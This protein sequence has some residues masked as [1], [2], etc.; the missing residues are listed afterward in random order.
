MK[1][2]SDR[3][4][5]AFSL[6]VTDRRW[7]ATLSAAALGF[8]LFV[9]V[10]IGPNAAGTL[11]GTAQILEMPAP[12]D[13]EATAA[14]ADPSSHALGGSPGSSGGGGLAEAPLAPIAL[15]PPPPVAPA[16]APSAE[17]E[18]APEPA[19][20]PTEPAEHE[21]EEETEL[22]GVVVQANPAAGSFAL[23]IDGGELVPV[24]A[25]ELPSAGAKLTVTA[26][27]LAN[28]TFVEAEPPKR[29]G[30]VVQASFRGVVTYANP[31]PVAPAYTVSGRG[32]SLLVHVDPD[33]SGAPPQLPVLGSRVTVAAA[34]GDRLDQRAI[35]VEEGEPSTYLDLA[36]IVQA[37]IPE[38]KQLVLSADGLDES[39][40]DLILTVP[41]SIGLARIELG[42][43]YLATAEVQPD[44]S[45]ALA[46]LASDEHTKGA[47][48]AAATQGDLKAG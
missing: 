5:R 26:R 46:G 8:G 48:D 33:P 15:A 22:K 29:S 36:G 9:G 42:E 37:V 28:G 25:Q 2:V 21:D 6:V 41:A 45:L 27:R 38:T 14:E 10:A 24:H 11:A 13:R 17:E 31:D 4:L 40:A 39:E 20:R 7:A 44:G 30:R 1:A 23:A 43:S 18:P 19:P 34:I 16:P 32:A 12:V 47:G 35:E 3:I